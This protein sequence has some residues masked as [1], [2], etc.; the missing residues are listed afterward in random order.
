LHKA[1]AQPS[2][3]VVGRPH[4]RG[5]PAMCWRISKIRFVY[6]SKRG[7]AQGIQCPK[8]VQGGNLAGRPSCMAGRPD[9][10]APHVHSLATTPPYSSYKYHGPPTESVRRVRFSPPIVLQSSFLWSIERGEVLRA[11]G[12]FGLSGVL[13]VAQV[14]KLCQN[15]FGFN[16]VF[17]PLVRSSAEAL[18]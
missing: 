11:R 7:S 6:V 8:A 12:F 9:K 14:W 16:G 5:Q 1:R 2:Q 10:W 15:L 4:H 18:L 17:H 13:G 3:G